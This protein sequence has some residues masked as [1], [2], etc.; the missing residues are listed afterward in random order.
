[1]QLKSERANAK[2]YFFLLYPFIRNLIG[3][4]LLPDRPPRQGRGPQGS[5]QQTLL[6]NHQKK[7]NT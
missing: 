5:E 6:K 4:T 2:R 1:M 7:M 3:C